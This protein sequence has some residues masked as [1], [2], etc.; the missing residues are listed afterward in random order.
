M[1][2]DTIMLFAAGLGN[3]M[4]HLTEN[5]PKTLIPILDKPILHYALELCASYPFKKIVI[6]THYMHEKINESI[7]E[8]KLIHPDFPEIV[9][10]YEEELLETGGGVK[11]AINELGDKPIFT[12]NTDI[13]L[14]SKE[15]IFEYMLS[16]WSPERMDFLLLMQQYEKSVG[17]SGRGDFDLD[18]NGGLIRPDK[19][20]NYQYVYT[21]LQI[22][23]PER[24]ARHPLKIFSLR[25]YYLNSERVIGIE[26]KG[27]K[28]YH[29]TNPEDIVNVEMAMLSDKSV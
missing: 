10:I 17:Y 25:E 19:E 3:R 11:N 16:K 4:R 26:S 1:I 18:S 27:I 14:K 2:I 28:W 24:I 22:L 23:K 15:N 7:E 12:L 6:N 5:S 9:I 13:V 8:F 20:E 21:G 29:V